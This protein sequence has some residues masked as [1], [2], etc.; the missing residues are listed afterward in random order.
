MKSWITISLP[1]DRQTCEDFFEWLRSKNI[2]TDSSTVKIYMQF[3][4][5]LILKQLDVCL[6]LQY[7]K[8]TF[9]SG[10]SQILRHFVLESG[11]ISIQIENV[12]KTTKKNS[13]L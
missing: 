2:L 4:N 12:L 6:C 5:P 11:K 8:L 10:P 3:E 1:S 9:C 7:S 13:I